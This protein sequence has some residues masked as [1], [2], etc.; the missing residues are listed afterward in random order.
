MFI[1]GDVVNTEGTSITQSSI[2]V[3]SG[4]FTTSATDI[5]T[6][7]IVN[8]AELILTGG[9]LAA[10][11]TITGSSGTLTVTGNLTSLAAI[12]QSTVS[13][14]N[15]LFDSQN[16][17]T[18]DSISVAEGAGLK[19]DASNLITTD[20]V[21]N[22][23]DVT[24][25]GGVLTASNTITGAGNLFVTGDF[26][27]FADIAQ[28]SVTITGNNFSQYAVL[29]ATDVIVKENSTATIGG[30]FEADQVLNDG[31]VIIANY[32]I[33]NSSAVYKGIGELSIKNST[34]TN[35]G[36][37]Q[38]STVTIESGANLTSNA[39]NITTI[40]GIVS[41]GTLTYTGGTNKNIISGNGQLIIDG[42][43]VNAE[44]TSITQSSI[45][46]S[47][48]S[49]TTSATDI[50]TNGI[51]NSALLTLTG[52]TLTETNVITG[53]GTL[54]VTDNLT[55]LAA[56][57]QSTININNGMFEN[58]T[59]S[60]ITATNGINISSAAGLSAYATDIATTTIN[61][62]GAL[63]FR[64]GDNYS[65]ISGSGTL[66]ITDSLNNYAELAQAQVAI[67]SGTTTNNAE[68]VT[69]GEIIIGKDGKIETAAKNLTAAGGIK[70]DGEIIFNSALTD[71]TNGNTITGMGALTIS[72]NTTVTNSAKIMLG[73]KMTIDDGS[74]FVTDADDLGI[75]NAIENEGILEYVGGTNNNDI[76][77]AGQLMISSGAVIN[78]LGAKITQST[79]TISSDSSFTT[80]ASDI[81]TTGAGII[82]DGILTFTGGVNTSTITASEEGKGTLIVTGDL[83][84]QA[85]ITQ[86]SI[87]ITSNYFDNVS[88]NSI[89]ASTLTATTRFMTDAADLNISD[90]IELTEADSML[91][92]RDTAATV[93]TITANITGNGYLVQSGAA[94]VIL[95][96]TNTYT[97][98]TTISDGALQIGSE[99]NISSNTI[100]ADGGKLIV[101]TDSGTVTLVN[102]FIGTDHNDVQIE[103]I[104]SS[105][106]ILTGAILGNKDLVKTGNGILNLLIRW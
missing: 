51:L 9:T 26:T 56:I 72:S 105:D 21:V 3:S 25:T 28:T 39:N 20:G 18:A 76:K 40:N 86:S 12:E 102:E 61:S 10:S 45:T 59:G 100:Y 74:K 32:L 92:F 93:S 84:N 67:T 5:T 65:T 91:Q 97:G 55:N 11:N 73:G 6:N 22:A 96:G 16:S 2:T 14:T 63:I 43:V 29:K 44:G 8:D 94:T 60:S 54:T 53:T 78:S 66:T 19:T 17:I 99:I 34:F 46:V 36:S 95:T 106:T 41:D 80:Y 89:T 24:L 58:V 82:D 42:E 77:G 71:D 85:A 104:G 31:K 35:N 79:I 75:A 23:G 1:S 7:G 50:T 30:E 33:N 52:G 83:V 101:N 64:G 49:F 57:T 81:T 48:G 88:G 90:S 69:T 98:T 70:D 103:V 27:G 68:I 15:G 37:I 47:S 13:I 62:N 38:Q 87:A 4:S